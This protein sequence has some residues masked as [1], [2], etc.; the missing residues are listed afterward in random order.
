M[1]PPY[2]VRD[3]SESIKEMKKA[4]SGFKKRVQC[5]R[6]LIPEDPC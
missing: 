2:E 5:L 6:K 4:R 1:F 3:S